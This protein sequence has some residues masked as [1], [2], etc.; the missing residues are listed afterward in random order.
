MTQI[1]VSQVIKE[2]PYD[3]GLPSNKDLDSCKK[4]TLTSEAMHLNF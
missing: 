2:Q 1:L 4:R 3:Q